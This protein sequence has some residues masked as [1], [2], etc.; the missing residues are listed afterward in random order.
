M[1]NKESL[2]KKKL[3]LNDFEGFSDD[4]VYSEFQSERYDSDYNRK[5][6]YMPTALQLIFADYTYQDYSGDAYVLGY[7]HLKECFFEV[8]GGHCSCYELE[9]QWEIEYVDYDDLEI[10]MERRLSE[11]EDWMNRSCMSSKELKEF[12]EIE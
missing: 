6:H 11:H 10:M 7:D 2:L 3:F 5:Q 8:H 4:E 12:L 1:T 9:G